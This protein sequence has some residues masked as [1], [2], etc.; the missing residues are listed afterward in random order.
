MLSFAPYHELLEGGAVSDFAYYCIPGMCVWP[1]EDTII[2]RMVVCVHVYTH[3]VG[4]T[5]VVLVQFV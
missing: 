4:N 2:C 5:A 3:T 1:V